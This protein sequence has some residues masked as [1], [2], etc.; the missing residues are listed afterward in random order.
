MAANVT[1]DTEQ[2]FS[3]TRTA[4]GMITPPQGSDG[5]V[6]PVSEVHELLNK[7]HDVLDNTVV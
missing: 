5:D 7:I 1:L 4:L 3:C 2:L 6:I